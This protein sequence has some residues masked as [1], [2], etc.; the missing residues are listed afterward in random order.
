MQYLEEDLTAHKCVDDDKSS[1]YILD[2]PIKTSLSYHT[3]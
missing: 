1:I 3:I 2:I